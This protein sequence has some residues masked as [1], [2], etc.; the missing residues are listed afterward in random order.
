MLAGNTESPRGG[1]ARLRGLRA[2]N[3]GRLRVNCR[4]MFGRVSP[5]AGAAE[6]E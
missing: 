5:A 6:V 3:P 2:R 4:Y 1:L